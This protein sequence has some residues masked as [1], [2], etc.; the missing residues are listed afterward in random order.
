MRLK[1]P[2]LPPTIRLNNFRPIKSDALERIDGYQHNTAVR[3]YTVLG[4]AI[5]YRVQYLNIQVLVQ[6]SSRVPSS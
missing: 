6:L 2:P 4:I 3:V 1:L 5:P